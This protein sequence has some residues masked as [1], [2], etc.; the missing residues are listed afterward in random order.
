MR[1]EIMRQKSILSQ[2]SP[3]INSQGKSK[4]FKI[5]KRIF[6]SVNFNLQKTII[7]LDYW[8]SN[9]VYS[10]IMKHNFELI[11]CAKVFKGFMQACL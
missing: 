9:I 10:K 4:L 7:I 11:I 5:F 3:L 1:G 8:K 6:D 2:I